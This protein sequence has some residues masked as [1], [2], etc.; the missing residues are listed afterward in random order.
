MDIQPLTPLGKSKRI[1][2]DIKLALNF[3]QDLIF[4]TQLLCNGRVD[5]DD[6]SKLKK[7]SNLILKTI[8]FH[9]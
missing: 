2:N 1:K 9:S 5:N 3:D 4:K 7:R 6:I 8:I